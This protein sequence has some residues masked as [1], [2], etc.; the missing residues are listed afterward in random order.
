MDD[1]TI[2]YVIM[3]ATDEVVNATPISVQPLSTFQVCVCVCVCV[4]ECVSE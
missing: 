1:H 3:P 2:L 4:C